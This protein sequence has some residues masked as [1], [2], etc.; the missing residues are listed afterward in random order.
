MSFSLIV[1]QVND[2]AVVDVLGRFSQGEPIQQFQQALRTH[3]DKGQRNFVINLGE[4]SYI[5]S[6]ALGAMITSWTSVRKLREKHGKGNVVLLNV[7]RFKELLTITSLFRVFDAFEDEA[8][9][10]AAATR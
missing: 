6:S 8:Q 4:C 2:A 3:Y 1:R 10:V 5:D 9:A 7:S